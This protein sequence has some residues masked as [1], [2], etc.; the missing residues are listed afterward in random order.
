MRLLKGGI[1]RAL[2]NHKT[3]EGREYRAYLTAL[4]ARLG[5]LPPSAR[6]FQREAGL[7]VVELVRVADEQQRAVARR[8]LTEARRLR[9][10]QTGLGRELRRLEARLEQLAATSAPSPTQVAAAI[11]ATR[12]ATQQETSH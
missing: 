9:R 3:R 5:P 1:P 6:P 7:V 4:E 2:R 11:M 12:E 8:R 10:T